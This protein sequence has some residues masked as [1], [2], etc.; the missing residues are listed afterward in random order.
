MPADKLKNLLNPNDDGNLGDIIDRARRM[1]EL[2]EILKS[3]LPGPDG[4]S[5][6]A[7]NLRDDGEMIVIC[8]SS[9]WATRLRYEAETLIRAAVD[10]GVPAETCRVRV[11]ID[12]GQ[13]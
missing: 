7:A 8:A 3:A 13:A 5:I 2:T 6:L 4:E 10:A 12:S 11:S 9:A 1:G